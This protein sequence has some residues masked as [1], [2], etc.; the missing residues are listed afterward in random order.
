ML[1]F[2]ETEYVSPVR[3]IRVNIR[4]GVGPKDAARQRKS[5]MCPGI[6]FGE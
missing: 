1:M 4:A 2:S 6:L 3:D 5:K